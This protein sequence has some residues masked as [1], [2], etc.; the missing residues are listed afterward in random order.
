MTTSNDTTNRLRELGRVARNVRAD[1]SA[2]LG[3]AFDDP[4]E[5][6]TPALNLDYIQKPEL[7]PP[8][9][10]APS[11]SDSRDSTISTAGGVVVRILEAIPPSARVFALLALVA[12]ATFLVYVIWGK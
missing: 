9:A 2:D 11:Q 7:Y 1:S 4:E 3:N 6:T 8:R 10:P 12:S 5:K